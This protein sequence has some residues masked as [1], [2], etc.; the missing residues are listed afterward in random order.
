[1]NEIAE[2][3]NHR[4]NMTMTYFQRTDK[5]NNS[6]KHSC[7]KIIGEIKFDALFGLIFFG[8]LLDA[9]LHLTIRHLVFS[10]IMSNKLYKAPSNPYFL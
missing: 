7:V 4:I 8:N 5:H 3:T 1:M 2:H 9:S 6:Y 10:S